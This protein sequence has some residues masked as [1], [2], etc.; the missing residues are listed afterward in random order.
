M[1]YFLA[2]HLINCLSKIGCILIF[3]QFALG[4]NFKTISSGQIY[5]I[6]T[7]IYRLSP[8]QI[9]GYSPGMCFHSA[10]ILLLYLLPGLAMQVELVVLQK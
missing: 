5:V 8:Q 6:M 9:S 10:H 3:D 7:Y 4:Q 2:V 1:Q